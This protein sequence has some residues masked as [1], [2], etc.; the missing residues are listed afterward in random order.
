MWVEWTCNWQRTGVQGGSEAV[1]YRRRALIRYRSWRMV[2]EQSVYTT[3]E[4][5]SSNGIGIQVSRR[6]RGT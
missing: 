1:E 3:V 4:D 5:I 2:D 6:Y